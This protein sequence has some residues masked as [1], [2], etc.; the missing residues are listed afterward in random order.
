MKENQ[1]SVESGV[2]GRRSRGR[3]NRVWMD[4][5]RKTLNN[6]ALT[7]EQARMAVHDSVDWREFVD[8]V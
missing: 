5:V 4:G 7:L 1:K 8:R 2:E 3:P 6:R